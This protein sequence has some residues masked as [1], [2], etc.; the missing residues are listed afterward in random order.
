MRFLL[1]KKELVVLEIACFSRNTRSLKNITEVTRMQRA[2][3]RVFK[4]FRFFYMYTM[5]HAKNK[6][7][8]LQNENL[9]KR[10]DVL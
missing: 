5:G 3:P 7:F 10:A 9:G 6:A 4:G 1:R 8:V 2:L